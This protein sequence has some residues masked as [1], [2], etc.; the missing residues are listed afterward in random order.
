MA[1][2]AYSLVVGAERAV[3]ARGVV[4]E[5]LAAGAR[6]LH[7]VH[8]RLAHHHRVAHRQD[9]QEL[10]DLENVAWVSSNLQNHVL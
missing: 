7:G 8:V 5:V 9:Q 2:T 3:G 6:Q 4:A 1:R 10:A